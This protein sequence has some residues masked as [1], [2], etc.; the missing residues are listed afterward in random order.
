ML[1]IPWGFW[2]AEAF[3]MTG[4]G[5][6]TFGPSPLSGY[7]LAVAI[8]AAAGIAYNEVMNVPLPRSWFIER[9]LRKEA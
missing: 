5:V 2:F 8:G 4:L 1:G 9:E 7:G 3:V 6:G